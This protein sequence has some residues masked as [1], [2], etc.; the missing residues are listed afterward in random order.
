MSKMSRR[1]PRNLCAF[2]L[3]FAV[4][5]ASRPS[6]AC[7]PFSLDAVFTFT[8]HPEFP[9]EKFARGELGMIQPTYARSYL[10][11]AYRYL[12]GKAFTTDEQK[13]LQELWKDRLDYTWPDYDEEWPKPWL[14]ARKKIAGVAPDPK[15]SISRHREK[16]NE[17]ETYINCQK[18]AF[19]NAAATLDARAKQF[20]PDSPLIKDWV[21]AQDQVFSNCSEGQSI[22]TEAAAEAPQ[23]IRADRT[24]QIAA[25][26]FY[27]GNFDE[28]RRLFDA[29]A[30]DSA[31]PWHASA[32]YLAARSLVRKASIGPAEGKEAA[33]AAAET[34]LRA[35]LSDRAL[36]SSH[37]AGERLLN[38][39]RL[40]LHPQEKLHELAQSLSTKTD[41]NTLKQDLWDYT[42]LLDQFV[43]EDQADSKKAPLPPVTREDDLTDWILTY[44][45][46]D[47]GALDHAVDRWTKTNSAAWLIAALA[48]IDASNPK[49]TELLGA[50]AKIRVESPAFASVVF[51]R[52][53]LAVNAGRADQARALLDELITKNRAAVPVSTLN[54][55]LA[56]R[57]RLATSLNDLLTYALRQPAGYSYNE[58]ERE[59]LAEASDMPEADK[60]LVGQPLFDIDGM[61]LLNKKLPLSLLKEAATSRVLPQHLRRDV[62]QATWIRA[63]LLGDHET[64]REL[65]PTAKTLIPKLRPFLDDYLAA[66]QPDEKHFTAIYTWLKFPGLEP[67]VDSG[68]GRSTPLEEQDSYRDNWWCSSALARD[69]NAAGEETE[70]TNEAPA[71]KVDRNVSSPQFLTAT[72]RSAA[73]R[74]VARLSAIGAAPNYLCHQAIE[75][76]DKH[77]N[78]PRVPEALHLAVKTTRFGCTDKET[79]KWSKAAFDVLHKRYPNSPWTKKTP[80]WFKD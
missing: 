63:V 60:P 6:H 35:I 2:A 64:A 70:K 49:A 13:V 55:L 48:K 66:A 65:V 57:M 18:D 51:Q 52:V 56:Q 72:Q 8:S 32:P 29:I 61:E 75:W 20:G 54:L 27:A 24:Y 23:L 36:A 34:Q 12:N 58:D 31:S 42:T 79:G 10:F 30:K 1:L 53:R 77:P 33:L 17:Y 73:Q 41:S 74:E 69:A 25:A 15:V 26:D 21:A 16:P 40:R 7:G 28:A 43:G 78:D 68:V 14:E 80:Y 46:K 39:V 67:V 62:V 22:P 38:I 47:A 11:V 50:A 5:Y 3:I 59:L 19:D 76:A 44:Q 37:G 45:E 9:L 71:F 4:L